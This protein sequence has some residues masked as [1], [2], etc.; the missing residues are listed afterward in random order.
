MIG[1]YLV[2]SLV[3]TNILVYRCDPS[4]PAKKDVARDLL[5]KG[6]VA[7][8][9][10]LPHQAMVEFVNAVTKRRP[11]GGSILS[12]EEALRQAEDLL[13]EF[14]ILYPNESLFRTA[15]L[16]MAAYRFSWYDAHLWAYAEHYGLP[17]ILSEDFE[18]GRRYGGV[19]IRNPFV[20]PGADRQL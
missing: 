3:D 11:G 10:R 2:A 19:R 20:V 1:A 5:R 18:H 17:E 6:V 8:D 16:G 13:N 12:R 7:N 15:L 4:D 9:L 14:P